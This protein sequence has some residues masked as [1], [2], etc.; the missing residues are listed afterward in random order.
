MARTSKVKLNGRGRTTV[1]GK[2][3]KTTKNP[4]KLKGGVITGIKKITLKGTRP[5]RRRTPIKKIVTI[6]VTK[7]TKLMKKFIK[8]L[9]S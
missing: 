6:P 2:G 4:P 8:D 7:V 3:S 1:S 5:E 9:K